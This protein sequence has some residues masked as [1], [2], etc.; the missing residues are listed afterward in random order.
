MGFGHKFWLGGPIDTRPMRLNYILQDLVRDTPLDN[1]WRTQIRAHTRPN[2]AFGARIWAS[3]IGSS[4]VSTPRQQPRCTWA[5]LA[6][7][8]SPALEFWTGS[9]VKSATKI[10]IKQVCQ[11]IWERYTIAYI[12]RAEVP[13]NRR[14][15][16]SREK[17]ITFVWSARWEN[18][19]GSF[20]VE[21]R[22]LIQ[23][24]FPQ[25]NSCRVDQ[26]WT[27]LELWTSCL[28]FYLA[29]FLKPFCWKKIWLIAY[30]LNWLD[31]SLLLL[32]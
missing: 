23:L 7:K 15:A 19:G 22:L 13:L 20:K 12:K 32:L 29:F 24:F 30:S 10:I 9:S 6:K 27:E 31:T 21:Q 11:L 3:Q 17:E 26:F 8:T 4:E 14:F 25:L 18:C 1:I 16:C 2:T 28:S 5:E